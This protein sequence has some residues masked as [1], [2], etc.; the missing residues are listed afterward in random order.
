M[1]TA[2]VKSTMP[3]IG[4]VT[5][6]SVDGPNGSVAVGA[7]LKSVEVANA[8]AMAASTA[9]TTCG[10]IVVP[11]IELGYAVAAVASALSIVDL[12][13]SKYCPPLEVAIAVRAAR[14]ALG[15]AIAIT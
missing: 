14:S 3:M 15:G 8:C 5:W 4:L 9:R 13:I 11:V 10:T 6:Y 7:V 12:V 1:S 2:L